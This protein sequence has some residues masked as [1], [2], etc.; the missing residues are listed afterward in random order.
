V[1]PPIVDD[2]RFGRIIVDGE[3]HDRDLIIF[4]DRIVTSWWRTQGHYLQ[5]ADLEAVLSDPPQVLVIGK[6][7]VG[8]MAIAPEAEQALARADIELLAQWSG[9]A[10]DT[11]NELSRQKRTVL[12]IHLT[13]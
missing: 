13:C 6:G 2:Y 1:T 5:A 10:C 7:A 8:R 3:P 4:P 9:K 12:A 11:Y